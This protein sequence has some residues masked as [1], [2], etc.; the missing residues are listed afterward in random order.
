METIQYYHLSKSRVSAGTCHSYSWHQTCHTR[1]KQ[2]S[3]QSLPSLLEVC[4]YQ[5]R[6]DGGFY[7]F[8]A[9][10]LHSGYQIHICNRS[11]WERNSP[12]RLLSFGTL[13]TPHRLL[14]GHKTH[15]KRTNC[16]VWLCTHR[17]FFHQICR[18]QRSS[19]K[20]Q[21][22]VNDCDAFVL[23]VYTMWQ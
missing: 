14:F 4:S 3:L 2:Y 13:P 17:L 22:K 23:N 11:N 20:L 18:F 10:I 6:S 1:H 15:Q 9:K 5:L 7:H 21:Q 8:Q 16:Q 12:I 19:C